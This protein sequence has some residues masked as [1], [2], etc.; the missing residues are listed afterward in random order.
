[1]AMDPE[2]ELGYDSFQPAANPARK[3]VTG[4]IKGHTCRMG[5]KDDGE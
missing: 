1:M 5:R 2:F 4:L 3:L